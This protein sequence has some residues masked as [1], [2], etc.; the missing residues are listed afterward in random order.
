MATSI[1][2]KIFLV[3]DFRVRQL[4]NSFMGIAWFRIFLLIYIVDE[5][6]AEWLQ[7]LTANAE[8]STVLCSVQASSGSNTWNLGGGMK[9]C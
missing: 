8:V 6:L 2:S 9:P 1:A 4:G 5:V 3:K 7:R